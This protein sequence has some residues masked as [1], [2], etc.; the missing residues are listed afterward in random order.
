MTKK[1]LKKKILIPLAVI[2]AGIVLMQL[3]ILARRAPHKIA[4]E[5]QGPL[6]EVLEARRVRLRVDVLGTGTVRPRR[7]AQIAPQ[8]EGRIVKVA[9]NFIVGGYFRKG[10]ILFEIER[11]DYELALEQRKADVARAEYDLATVE[12]QARVA[13]L[14]WENL[15]NHGGAEP[16]PL[17]LFEPQ[18]KRARAAL[19]SARAALEKARL[20]LE[21]TIVHAPF[22]CRVRS[23][24][25]DPGQ[26][27]RAGTPAGVVSGTGTAEIVVP[28]KLED[29]RW[30][31]VPRPG[32]KDQGSQATVSITVDG[33][34]QSWQGS[35]VRDLGEVDPR[36][37]MARVVVA[38]ED[39]YGMKT[40]RQDMSL[41]MG[42]FVEVLIHGR[43]LPDVFLLP[44]ASLRENSTVWVVDEENML[45]IRPVEVVRR[46]QEEVIISDG[47]DEGERVVLTY[48][49]GAAEGMKLRPG[50]AGGDR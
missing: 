49:S 33:E 18:L 36:G 38:V 10:E 8:V 20:N 47:L 15:S 6:V 39:P 4:Q 17:V 3:M 28:L 31:N 23:E 7:E 43:T 34:K 24:T 12:S 41:A 30:I 35:V 25:I 50:P 5:Y 19:A 9:G 11:V 16:N 26:F 46:Q 45:R 37:R 14:E 32:T 22:D 42:M 21:R 40:G 13:R 27:V 1:D 44:S 29:F 48:L 2:A